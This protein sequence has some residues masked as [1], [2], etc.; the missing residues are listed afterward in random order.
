GS[1]DVS[2]SPTISATIGGIPAGSGYTITL[3]ATSVED[4]TS[5]TGS[6]KFDVTAGHTTPVTVHLK[7]VGASNNGSVA[8]NATLNLAPVVDELTVTPQTVFVGSSVD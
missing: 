6:A 8:V 4:E 7:G 5:F 2:D 3:L 1:I